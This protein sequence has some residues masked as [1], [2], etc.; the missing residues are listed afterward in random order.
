MD[1]R[2]RLLTAATVMLIG[3]GLA[4]FFRRSSGETNLPVIIQSDSLRVAQAA[5]LPDV[6]R[7]SAAR[8][9]LAVSHSGGTAAHDRDSQRAAG[10]APGVAQ[11]LPH[12]WPAARD[13]LG[14]LDE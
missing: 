12:G 4:L 1:Q 14:Q 2:L 11:E 6:G 9:A 5:G 8:R 13:A 10:L 3:L 7:R